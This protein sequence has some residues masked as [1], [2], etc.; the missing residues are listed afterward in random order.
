[1][2]PNMGTS[3]EAKSRFL[4]EARAVAVLN[5]PNV[6]TIFEI[7]EGGGEPFIVMEYVLRDLRAIT[8]RKRFG[9]CITKGGPD[10]LSAGKPSSR[11]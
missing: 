4:H 3:I 1:M 8:R 11:S 6:A 9:S 5:H 7:E 2:P 10:T